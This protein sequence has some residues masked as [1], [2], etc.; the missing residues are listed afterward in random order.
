MC[1]KDCIFNPVTRIC[2]N[3]KY[4]GNIIDNSM[5]TSDEI[6]ATTKAALTKTVPTNGKR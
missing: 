2:E 4:V 5:I 1:E 3:G 6:I